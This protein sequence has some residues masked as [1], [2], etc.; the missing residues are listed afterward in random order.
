M[1]NLEKTEIADDF[2]CCMSHGALAKLV[3]C[4][5]INERMQSDETSS[6]SCANWSNKDEGLRIGFTLVST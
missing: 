4:C 2:T 1:P 3:E 5:S 6:I